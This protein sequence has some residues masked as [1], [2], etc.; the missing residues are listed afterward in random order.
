MLGVTDFLIKDRLDAALL[1]RSI[2]YA[3]RHHAVLGELRETPG[4]LCARREGGERRDL[5][6]GPAVG[7]S[8][9]SA[10]GGRRCS[11]TPRR[12][13]ATPPKS[14][15]SACAPTISSACGPRS[16]LTSTGATS[17]FESEHRIRHADGSIPLGLQSRGRGSRPREPGDADGR[18][19]VR[20]HRPQGRRGAAATRCPPRLADRAAE[21]D[22]V[23][24]PP[25]AV[26]QSSQAQLALSL[27]G[28][29][30]R[31]QPL[32]ASQRRLQ[33][34]GGRSAAGGAR[35]R[36]PGGN[37]PGRHA[38]PASAATSSPFSCTTSN[39]CE[40]AVEVAKR[41]H[42]HACASRSRPRAGA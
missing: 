19:D 12:R 32:Q 37:A 11:V 8:V 3:V 15:S 10:R 25:G 31:P 33:P 9:Y 34:R 1:E 17:H 14:G 36:A 40:A 24:R 38:S 29:V 22:D 21:P 41:I 6:L 26:A 35:A 4:P 28:P 18:L 20:H 5:G 30:P 7:Q 23:P 2:R 39:P 16:T 27:R 13:S 42:R